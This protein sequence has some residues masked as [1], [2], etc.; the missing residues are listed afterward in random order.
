MKVKILVLNL[1]KVNVNA[2]AHNVV[3]YVSFTKDIGEPVFRKL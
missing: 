1:K 2:N 3:V